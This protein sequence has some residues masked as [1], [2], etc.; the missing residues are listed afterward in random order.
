MLGRMIVCPHCEG[1]F[2][3][4]EVRPARGVAVCPAC[5]AMVRLELEDGAW[6]A[7]GF[8]PPTPP[9]GWSL[10]HE[11]APRRSSADYREAV[12][13]PGRLLMTRRW[14]TPAVILL[15]FFALAWDAFLFVWYSMT[16]RAPSD[17]GF[18]L[19]AMLFP[20][21]HVAIGVGL[22]WW[23]LT[24]WLNRTTIEVADGRL[25]CRHGPI[26]VPFAATQP[27]SL[28]DVALFEVTEPDR[29]WAKPAL[30]RYRARGRMQQGV[31]KMPTLQIE[32]RLHDGRKVPVVTRLSDR[33][34]ADYLVRKLER[35]L[36]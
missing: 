2:G 9:E 31:E 36:G 29:W 30:R 18:S 10:R 5:H 23:V 12:R 6:R 24:S 26:P 8:T 21:G 33:R 13:E 20:I 3:E 25:T 7:V 35:Q 15:T 16:I 1:S 11:E 28:G 4:L 32:A 19:L 27:V 34:H 17:D 14:W 22:T